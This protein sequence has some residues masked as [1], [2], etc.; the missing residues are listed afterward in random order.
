VE[1]GAR[2]PNGAKRGGEN[3]EQKLTPRRDGKKVPIVE[4]GSGKRGIV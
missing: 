2:G 4:E 1:K 3:S